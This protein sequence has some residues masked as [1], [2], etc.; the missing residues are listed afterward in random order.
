MTIARAMAPPSPSAAP[1]TT[2]ASLSRPIG[3][4]VMSARTIAI[5]MIASMAVS[6]VSCGLRIGIATGFRSQTET[7]PKHQRGASPV[8]A[9]DRSS[10][11]G[12][13]ASNCCRGAMLA[14]GSQSGFWA[15]VLPVACCTN[16]AAGW[17]VPH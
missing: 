7:D 9:Y 11:F 2:E 1:R 5:H 6:K 16:A 12:V 10:I 8:D 15:P 14:G 13:A 3:R 17:F 4:S